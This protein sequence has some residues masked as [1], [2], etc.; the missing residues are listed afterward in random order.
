[1]PRR[2]LTFAV[3]AGV[4]ALAVLNGVPALAN[5]DGMPTGAWDPSCADASATY[6][7]ESATITPADGS[8]QPLS[9]LGLTASATTLASNDWP[10]ALRWSVDGWADQPADVTA[11]EVSLVIRTG[12][13]APR[14]TTATADTVR[15]T[16]GGDDQSGYV[17]TLTG[18]AAHVDWTTNPVLAA[19]CSDA[20]TCGDFNSTADAAGTGVRFAGLSLDLDG[21]SPDDIAVLDGTTVASDSQTYQ[22]VFTSNTFGDNPFLMIGSFGNPQLDVSGDPVSNRVSVWLPPA[23]VAA[24]P[25]PAMPQVT[26]ISAIGN[27]VLTPA[28][29]SEDGGMRLEIAK[30]GFGSTLGMLMIRLGVFSVTPATG[31]PDMPEQ[32]RAMAD[33]SGGARISWLPPFSDHGSAVTA[34][35]ARAYLNSTT[36][37][38]SCTSATLSCNLTGLTASKNYYVR[39]SAV[40]ALGEGAAAMRAIDRPTAPSAPRTPAVAA[41][42]GRLTL[43]W[44]APLSTGGQPTTGYTVRAYRTA[45]GGTA[46]STCL[47]PATRL[48]CTVGGLTA[49]ARIYLSVLATNMAGSS[50]ETAR[51]YGNGW[52][53]ATA[54]RTPK[55]TSARSRVTVS[56]TAPAATGGT[57][58]TGYRADLWTAVRGGAVAARCTSK[59]T[60]RTCVSPALTPGRT[61]YA[62]VTA[63]NAVGASAQPARVKVV[64]KR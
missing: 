22:R 4:L 34:Y 6:C 47:A 45:T 50:A 56:W 29:S 63:L 19:Q 36:L 57:P 35:R 53:V 48:N 52:T 5:V 51:V 3:T 60:V 28:Q 46:F 18:K 23:Y 59:G 32:V 30:L 24:A 21:Y 10:S 39:V 41:G 62:T 37:I 44:T 64:V 11:G 12:A 42:P 27:D 20:I 49:G 2:P 13:Y 38:G 54:P 26:V 43:S 16:R 14:V 8:A 17:L 58:V 9:D 31:T 15:A 40:S 1:M 25:S 61:Y 33:V 55:A 7:I